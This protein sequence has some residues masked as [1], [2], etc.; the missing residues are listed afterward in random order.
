M[1]SLDNLLDKQQ[2]M[3]MTDSGYK[4]LLKKLSY[5]FKVIGL[6]LIV[7]GVV[8][9]FSGLSDFP[10]RSEGVGYGICVIFGG[11]FVIFIGCVGEAIDDI[12]KNTGK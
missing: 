2:E 11:L 9:I 1:G 3:S 5:A 12:R 7:F 10:R 8:V 4:S 6:L